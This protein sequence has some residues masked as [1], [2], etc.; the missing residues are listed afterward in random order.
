MQTRP[1]PHVVQRF[2]QFHYFYMVYT[3]A[4]VP[5]FHPLNPKKAQD[6]EGPFADYDFQISLLELEEEF[7]LYKVTEH[8]DFSNIQ[9]TLLCI[10]EL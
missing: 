3:A 1:E 5:F 2:K 4:S 8:W 10:N 7:H 6:V 9:D